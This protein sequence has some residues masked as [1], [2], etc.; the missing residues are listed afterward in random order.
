MEQ[1]SY[2]K[3]VATKENVKEKLE[4]YGVA[5]IPNVL[6][7][8]ECDAMYE[9][10]WKSIEWVTQK[11]E[12]PIKKDD[13]NSWKS[14]TLL[15]PLHHQLLQRYTL[16][17]AQYYWDIRQNEK[18]VAIFA[19]FWGI[20]AEELLVSF[21]GLSLCLPPETTGK[22][23]HKNDWLHVDQSY[24]NNNLQS[25]Q[26][27]VT[28]KDVEKGDAT[29][30][31]LHKSHRYHSKFAKKFNIT[32]KSDWYKL[33]EKEINYYLDKGCEQKSIYCPK[34]SLVM[35]DSRT[36]H[37]GQNPIKGRDNPNTRSVVYLCYTLRVH[38]TDVNIKKKIK[39]FEE[40]RT[41][42]HNP[43]KP[44]LFPVNARTYGNPVPNITSVDKP[45]LNELG[46]KLV[47]Y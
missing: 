30:T 24:T 40:L 23:W 15:Y 37:A 35:F 12:V 17:H 18:I 38:A 26:S 31:F 6:N 4:K 46:K 29:L 10:M 9:G 41:T 47:G 32:D 25:I 21:D 11:F 16:T 1:Y 13:I 22:G 20:K 36:V 42:S 3:Y 44:K 34:G 14:F 43:H 19:H 5:I 33:D 2:K 28:A 27:W 45:V 8:E 39:A 7:E